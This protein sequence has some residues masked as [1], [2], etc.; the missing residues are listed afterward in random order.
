ME[1]KKITIPIV[2]VL[3]IA[4][5]SLGVAFAAFSTTLNIN[6][7]AAVESTTWDI[8]FTSQDDGPKPTQ[9]T[10]V[11]AANISTG[12]TTAEN[13]SASY[14][15]TTYTWNAS[16][17]T[18]GDRIVYTIYVKNGGSYNAQVSNITKPAITCTND[19]KSACSHLSYNLYT[20]NAGNTPLTTSFTVDAGETEVFYLIATLDSSYGGNDGS[21]LVQSDLTTD[22]ISATV[23]FQQSSSAVSNSNSGNSGG[24]GGGNTPSGDPFVNTD[25]AY[26]T[27][28]SKSFIGTGV[29]NVII[30]PEIISKAQYASANGTD[31]GDGTYTFADSPAADAAAAY[32]IGCRLM[33]RAEVCTWGGKTSTCDSTSSDETFKNKVK[34]NYQ[35]SSTGWWLADAYY[36]TGA[37]VVL[38][39][40]SVV[41]RGVTTSYGV[42]P[43][44]SIQAG[45]TIT[46]QGTSGNPY[47]ITVSE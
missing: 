47:V 28:D 5:V 1:N 26:Y 11:P 35:G 17:K 41:S 24:N 23:T 6:G 36:A 16:F 13:I 20:D 42:R 15:A 40:G 12:G 43:V 21:G 46:G 30:T 38:G 10:T 3:I 34:A 18:P 8:F 7:T 19:T 39:N 4:V 29:D 9:S 44:V 33:T 14:V 27:Y 31:N 32:C 45:A 37:W 2:I 25:G 22:A